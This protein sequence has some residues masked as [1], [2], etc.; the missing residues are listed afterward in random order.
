MPQRHKANKP[1]IEDAMGTISFYEGNGAS[2]SVVQTV[3]DKAGQNF[4]PTENDEIRS[5]KLTDVRKGAKIR[6]FDSTKGSTDDD[7][8]TITV[9]KPHGHGYVVESFESS[10]EDDYVKVVYAERNG[11]DGKVSRIRID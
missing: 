7:H 10:Y 8:C 9:K 1:R 4:K 5:A 6:V 2:Q 11:L 3:T